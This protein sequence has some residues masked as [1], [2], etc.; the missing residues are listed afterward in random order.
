MGHQGHGIYRCN[1]CGY[2]T[3]G[4]YMDRAHQARAEQRP[5]TVAHGFKRQ[6]LVLR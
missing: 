3:N 5:G 6:G 4:T 2:Q 1:Q